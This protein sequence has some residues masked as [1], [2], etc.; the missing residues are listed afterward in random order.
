[1][2]DLWGVVRNGLW[3]LGLAVVLAA[4]SIAR[5]WALKHA[6]KL[7]QVLSRPF[8]LVPFSA[9]VALFCLGLALSGQRWWE[10]TIWAVLTVL[11]VLLGVS[12]WLGGRRE[13]ASARQCQDSES[14]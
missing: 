10:T 11:F 4:W 12:S 1:M 2:I 7:R 14:P 3:I 5:W 6:V 9:G 13:T 8:F